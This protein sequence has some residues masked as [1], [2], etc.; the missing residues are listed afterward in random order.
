VKSITHFATLGTVLHASE[1]WDLE[2][3]YQHGLSEVYDETKVNT[4]QLM[5]YYKF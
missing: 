4:I 2:L 1:K 5:G 3:G